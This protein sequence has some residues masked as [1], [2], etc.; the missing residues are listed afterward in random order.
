MSAGGR[1]LPPVVVDASVW[2]AYYLPADA[3]HVQSAVWVRRQVRAKRTLFIPALLPAELAGSVARISNNTS[4]GVRAA[5][6][7]LRLSG[8]RLVSLDGDLAAEAALLAAR[9]RLRGADSLY[10]ALARK[11]GAQLVSWDSEQI[12]RAGAVAPAS[13]HRARRK[14]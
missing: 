8:V 9:L 6:A 3:F 7:V 14:S 11:L 1:V 10:V 5:R 12:A 2:V 4:L 13:S